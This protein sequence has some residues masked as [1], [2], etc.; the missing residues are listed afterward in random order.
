MV[1]RAQPLQVRLS[2]TVFRMERSR[3]RDA[4][5]ASLTGNLADP[6]LQ[7]VSRSISASRNEPAALGY[8][9]VYPADDHVNDACSMVSSL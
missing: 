7:A 4:V 6:T 8:S 9:K 3:C 2:D 5:P 1:R